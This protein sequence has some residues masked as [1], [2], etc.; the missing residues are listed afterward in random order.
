[1]T[2]HEALQTQYAAWRQAAAILG[3]EPPSLL[4]GLQLDGSIAG[5]EVRVEE[6]SQG[7]LPITRIIVHGE[8]YPIIRSIEPRKRHVESLGARLAGGDGVATGDASFD[9]RVIVHGDAEKVAAL[10]DAPTRHAIGSGVHLADGI[11]T[12]TIQ[13]RISSAGLLARGVRATVA[14]AQRLMADCDVPAQLAAN[15]RHDPISGVRL[16]N[17]A[18]LIRAFP[19]QA[20]PVLRS[21]LRDHDP[22]V[23]LCAALAL[24]EKAQGALRSLAKC[25]Q[26]D[27]ESQVSA[28]AALRAPLLVRQ[29]VRV[30]EMALGSGRHA[31]AVAAVRMLGERGGAEAV[32]RLTGLLADD[33]TELVLASCTALGATCD[34]AAAPT[35]I[36]ALA[37]RWPEVRVAAATALGTVGAATG[38]APLH[39]A[40]AAHPLDF[41]LRRAANA[42]VAA[43]QSRIKGAELGQLSL[44]EGSG[45]QLSLGSSVPAGQVSLASTKAAPSAAK[46]NKS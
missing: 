16:R 33:D 24:K 12:R 23:R 18:Q 1:M 39:A 26:L 5:L 37:S 30:L 28:L 40:A 22:A 31:V 38:V 41:E 13:R 2:A 27:E 44:A 25:Q 36:H 32:A 20:R 34:A 4:R 21:A 35:L 17:L 42:A 7:S 14:L 3:L 10:L 6:R 19:E 46:P 11:L 9:R 8:A 15:V 29:A 45:G 43:I